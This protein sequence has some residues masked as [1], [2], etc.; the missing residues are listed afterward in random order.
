MPTPPEGEADLRTLAQRYETA[1]GQVRELLTRAPNG[2]RRTLLTAA[3]GMLVVLRKLDPRGAITTAYLHEVPFGDEAAVDD[4]AGSLHKALDDGVRRAQTGS[5]RAF[6]LATEENIEELSDEAVLAHEGRDGTRWSLGRWATMQTS[7]L[8]RHSTSRGF[9]DNAGEGT[10]F[11]V[12]GSKCVL[13]RTLF[14]GVKAVGR[15][16]L[17]PGHPGCDCLAVRV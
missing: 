5:R 1:E 15:D 9:A 10:G 16:R 11:V 2:D 8:G 7:T 3:L 13:C 14:S 6:R 4:L 17:P 12:Q